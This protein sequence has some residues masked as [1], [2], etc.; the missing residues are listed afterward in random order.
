MENT[1]DIV[2][3]LRE[4]EKRAKLASKVNELQKERPTLRKKKTTTIIDDDDDLFFDLG[5]IL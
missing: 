2:E 3:Q 5:R 4:E 1:L